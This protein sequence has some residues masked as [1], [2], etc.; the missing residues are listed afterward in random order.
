MIVVVVVVGLML[1]IV[2][3]NGPMR[4]PRLA[5]AAAARD[6][7]QGLRDAAARAIAQDRTTT[8]RLDPAS[9]AWR[10]GARHGT[11]PAGTRLAFR[12]LATSN[13]RSTPLATVVFAQDG[14]ASGG[15]ITLASPAGV[16]IITID[17]LTGRIRIDAPHHR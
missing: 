15:R 14:S 10:E 8:F 9:G 7:V 16:A 6:I 12:G 4:S 11:I 13:R 2:A 17:W 1:G 5:E 3:S